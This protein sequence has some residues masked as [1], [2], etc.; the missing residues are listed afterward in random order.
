[1]EIKNYSRDKK[2]RFMLGSGIDNV[3]EIGYG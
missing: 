3:G 2:G 1:M